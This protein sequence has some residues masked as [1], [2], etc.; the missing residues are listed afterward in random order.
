MLLLALD[1]NAKAQYPRRVVPQD[2]SLVPGAQE[3]TAL[4]ELYHCPGR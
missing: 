1:G 3:G 4:D 2:Q